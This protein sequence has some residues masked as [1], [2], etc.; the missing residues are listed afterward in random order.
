MGQLR[1]HGIQL[2]IGLLGA[3]LR[4]RTQC[5]QHTHNCMS[6]CCRRAEIVQG[7]TCVV[8]HQRESTLECTH[9]SRICF[10]KLEVLECRGVIDQQSLVLDIVS[11]LSRDNI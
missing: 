7:G 9:P 4:A 6:S 3:V 10:I 8:G 5:S 11:Y 1:D 2:E